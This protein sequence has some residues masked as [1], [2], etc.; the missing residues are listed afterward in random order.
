VVGAGIEYAFAPNW[1]A[2]VEY[3]HADYG[4]DTYAL[5]AATNIDFKTDT[6][7]VGVNYLFNSG[8]GGRW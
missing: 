5:P 4:S 7:K 3:L 1:S 2:K 6:V 8:G